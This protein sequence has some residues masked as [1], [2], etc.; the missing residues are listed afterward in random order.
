MVVVTLHC[1][2]NILISFGRYLSAT[3]GERDHTIGNLNQIS[4][5]HGEIRKSSPHL[6]TNFDLPGPQG[7]KT[8]DIKPRA[9]ITSISDLPRQNHHHHV[10]P[11]NEG[12]DPKMEAKHFVLLP[13][14][15]PVSLCDTHMNTHYLSPP[16]AYGANRLTTNNSRQQPENKIKPAKRI[17]ITG[18]FHTRLKINLI[19]RPLNTPPTQPNPL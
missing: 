17:L 16:H 14:F 15:T 1:T 18:L 7:E 6:S 5:H 10:T 3:P 9:Y 8:V 13:T 4:P 12:T 11:T 2:L 19:Q